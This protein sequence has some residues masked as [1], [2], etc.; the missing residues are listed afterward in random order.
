MLARLSSKSSPIGFAFSSTKETFILQ[1]SLSLLPLLCRFPLFSAQT[2]Q[3]IIK[4]IVLISRRLNPKELWLGLDS[5][6]EVS[7]TRLEAIA[8]EEVELEVDDENEPE[9]IPFFESPDDTSVYLCRALL[10]VQI[11]KQSVS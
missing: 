3:R 8:D 6:V 5:V 10:A 1:K 9:E 2:S 4:L 7:R 11:G